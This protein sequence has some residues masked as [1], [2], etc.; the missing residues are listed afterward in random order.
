MPA[1][2]SMATMPMPGRSM[3]TTA[4]TNSRQDLYIDDGVTACEVCSTPAR[5]RKCAGCGREG[6]I[7]DCGHYPQP[8]PIAPMGIFGCECS[9]D[10]CE[11]AAAG[12][13]DAL[14]PVGE[15]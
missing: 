9:C 4:M 7:V 15:A 14:E 12:L 10:E 6:W 3:I 13:L 11:A 5:L 2:C 8:R 1:L